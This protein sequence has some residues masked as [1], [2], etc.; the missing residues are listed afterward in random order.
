MGTQYLAGAS[1]KHLPLLKETSA[2][3]HH[4]CQDGNK[5]RERVM[6]WRAAWED[7]GKLEGLAKRRQWGQS[8]EVQQ[9]ALSP[10][11]ATPCIGTGLGT[12]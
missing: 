11:A 5:L 4:R 2:V 6:S 12:E 7:R 10:G 8:C 9:E 1:G 3:Y